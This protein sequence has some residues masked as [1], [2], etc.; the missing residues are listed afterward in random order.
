MTPV[1]WGTLS[2]P[3]TRR[4]R[5]EMKRRNRGGVQSLHGLSAR[6]SA[7]CCPDRYPLRS[8]ACRRPN[9]LARALRLSLR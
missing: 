9:A 5:K 1:L 7:N 4:S 3:L 6:H 2:V 8:G